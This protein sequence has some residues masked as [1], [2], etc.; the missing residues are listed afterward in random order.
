MS[1]TSEAGGFVTAVNLNVGDSLTGVYTMVDPTSALA[2]CVPSSHEIV[3]A[4]G[5]A[6]AGAAKLTGSGS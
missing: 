1:S 3:Q 4:N 5:A 2:N 6:W